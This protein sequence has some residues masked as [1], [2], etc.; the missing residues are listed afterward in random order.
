MD[1]QTEDHQLLLDAL[2]RNFARTDDNYKHPEMFVYLTRYKT[3]EWRLFG[4]NNWYSLGYDRKPAFKDQ[5]QRNAVRE[6]LRKND[7]D[8][9]IGIKLTDNDAEALSTD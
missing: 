4:T 3:G 7:P 6:E 5:Q 2:S 1:H 8:I 9:K